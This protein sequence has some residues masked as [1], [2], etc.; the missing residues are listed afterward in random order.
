[1]SGPRYWVQAWVQFLEKYFIQTDYFESFSRCVTEI[2]CDKLP[3]LKVVKA[4]V[5]IVSKRFMIN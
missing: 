2:N 5:L 4:C 1:M 3:M